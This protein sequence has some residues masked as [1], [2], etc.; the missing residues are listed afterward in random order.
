MA[1]IVDFSQHTRAHGLDLAH[2]EQDMARFALKCA[3]ITQ[4]GT[5]MGVQAWCA[6]AD[7][8][9]RSSQAN[10]RQLP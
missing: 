6:W 7:S 10:R 1:N 3:E 8:Q 2:N 4:S 5:S 9:K